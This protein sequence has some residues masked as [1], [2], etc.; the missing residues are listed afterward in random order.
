MDHDLSAVDLFC[1]G[2]GFSEGFRQAG[3]DITHAIDIDEEACDTYRLNHPSTEV[4]NSNLMEYS[5][6]DLPEDTDVLIGSPPCGEFST[7]KRGGAG[8]AEEGM[9]LVDRFLYFVHELEPTHWVM[10]NVPRL[11]NHLTE[12]RGGDAGGIPE[13]NEGQVHIDRSEVFLCSDYGTPQRR[14]RLLSGRFPDPIEPGEDEESV[15]L[16]QVRDDYPRPSERAERGTYVEDP[17]YERLRVPVDDLSDHFYDTHLTEREKREIQLLKEDHSFYGPM[18]FPDD[19]EDTART[20]IAM[21]RRIARETIVLDEGTPPSGA[22]DMTRY[23][24]PTIRELATIQGFPITYQFTGRSVAQKRRRVGDAVPPPMAY[25]LALGVLQ[26]EGYDVRNATPAVPNEVPDLDYDLSDL[27]TTPRSRRK[28]PLTRNFRHHVPYDDMREFRVDI[29]T[30]GDPPIHP[31]ANAV[32][33]D[34]EHPVRFRAVFY[35]G[36]AKSV[37]KEPVGID[38]SL[39]FLRDYVSDN[40]GQTEQVQGFLGALGDRLDPIVPDA[41]TLQGI[42]T[43]R[44]THGDPREYEILDRIAAKE[45]REPQLVDEFFPQEEHPLSD[46]HPVGDVLGGTEMPVRTLMKLVAANYVAHKLNHCGR[47]ITA[48]REEVFLPED[49]ELT[50]EQ[51][52]SRVPCLSRAP[53]NGCIEDVVNRISD[54]GWDKVELGAQAGQAD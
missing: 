12:F 18:A 30:A 44:A 31:V 13:L 41:T 3:F 9:K 8:N 26:A 51:I 19:K 7:S 25:R 49:C 37:R 50:P 34:L 17:V 43:R 21:N 16:D 54:R 52:P 46:R 22:P 11:E 36:Y 6:A 53:A 23:R 10:E 28:L 32:G 42:R 33:G 40:P 2:G 14:R 39:E 27:G 15:L 38:R 47:W 1:G 48:N 45:G 29:E 20:V 4:I 24:K 35:E 5:P